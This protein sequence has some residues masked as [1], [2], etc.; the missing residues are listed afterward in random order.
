MG[1]E[2]VSLEMSL[3]CISAQLLYV[4]NISGYTRD[5]VL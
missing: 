3:D 5:Y 1:V 4:V 2:K